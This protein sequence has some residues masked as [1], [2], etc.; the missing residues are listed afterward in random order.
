MRPSLTEALKAATEAARE[1]MEKT[2]HMI[3]RAG[4]AKTLGERALGH[5]DPGAIS[6]YLISKAMDEWVMGSDSIDLDVS[7]ESDST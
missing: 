3:A 5:P 4:K 7:M 2:R 1:G 6:T